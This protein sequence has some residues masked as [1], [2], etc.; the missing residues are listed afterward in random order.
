MDIQ[1]IHGCM[2]SHFHKALKL[3]KCIIAIYMIFHTVN[4]FI[5]QLATQYIILIKVTVP[6][7]VEELQNGGTEA[8]YVSLNIAKSV[9]MMC[10]GHIIPYAIPS[11][12]SRICQSEIDGE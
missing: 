12:A 4:K 5:N 7:E 8:L 9:N 2:L 6:Y 10:P 3:L 11:K 1:Y